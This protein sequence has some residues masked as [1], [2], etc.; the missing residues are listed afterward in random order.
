MIGWMI[1]ITAVGGLLLLLSAA[2]SDIGVDFGMSG[3]G[4]FLTGALGAFMGIGGGAGLI[5]L[6]LGL[7][8]FTTVGIAGLS[9]MVASAIVVKIMSWMLKHSSNGEEQSQVRSIG[10]IGRSTDHVEPG[11]IGSMMIDLG[12][13]SQRMFFLSKDPVDEDQEV[14]VS[15]YDHKRNI[16]IVQAVDGE[17]VSSRGPNSDSIN[18]DAVANDLNHREELVGLS[19]TDKATGEPGRDDHVSSSPTR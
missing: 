11:E 14:I 8:F 2:G 5:T 18:M 15:S 10:I 6:G 7:P 9:G 17:D 4:S 13:G 19:G 12:S 3:G 16:M 1:G